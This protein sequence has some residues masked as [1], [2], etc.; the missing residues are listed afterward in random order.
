MPSCS[1]WRISHTLMLS[2]GEDTSTLSG[3]R[4]SSKGTTTMST[5]PARS[6]SR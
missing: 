2:S 1:S 6:E 4:L 3:A 5:V